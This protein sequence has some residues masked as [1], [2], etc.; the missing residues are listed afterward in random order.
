IQAG[1]VIV[2]TTGGDSVDA[3]AVVPIDTNPDGGLG[4]PGEFS[5]ESGWNLIAPGAT[6]DITTIDGNIEDVDSDGEVIDD[7]TQLDSQAQADQ[8]GALDSNYG[9]FEGTWVF[10]DSDG[11]LITEYDSGQDAVTYAGDVLNYAEEPREPE[12]DEDDEL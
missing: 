1:E 9:A 3:D 6:D 7:P 4:D 12:F 8:P 10:L 2:F 11:T 5:A